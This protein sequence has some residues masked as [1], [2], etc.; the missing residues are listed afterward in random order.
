V[1]VAERKNRM[2]PW[3]WRKPPL[4]SASPRC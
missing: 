2:E 1:K 4:I 3:P